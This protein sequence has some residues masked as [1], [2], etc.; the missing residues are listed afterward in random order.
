MP[1]A[2]ESAASTPNAPAYRA[3]PWPTDKMPPGIPYIIGNEAAE[4]FSYYG[5]NGILFVFLTEHLRNKTGAASTMS[6]EQAKEWVHYFIAAVYAFP[7]LGAILSDWL[8]GKYRTILSLS[9]VYCL[10][11][12]AL[13]LDETRIGLAVGLGLIALGSGGIKPCVSAHLG[14]QFGVKNQ[15][16]LEKVFSW[17]YFSI[18]FGA[19]FSTLLT[20]FLLARFGPHVAF[21]LPGLL[22]LLATWVFWLG[23]YK[24][25]HIPPGGWSFIRETFGR[26]GLTT[27]LRLAPIYACMIVFWSLY[28]QTGSSWVLQADR[29]NRTVTWGEWTFEIHAAQVH[30][31]NPALI[32]VFIPIFGFAIYPLLERIFPLTPLRKMGLG[33]VLPAFRSL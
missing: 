27:I 10:G 3:T 33:F 30:A 19:F 16:M 32:M 11:H 8:L 25:V 1:D 5:M 13:A 17:F 31:A 14:D 9:I 22:M 18:N 20:P 6:P 4:R 7:I 24:F 23:R 21:G 2:T 15:H 26:A 12:L 28:D 29:M